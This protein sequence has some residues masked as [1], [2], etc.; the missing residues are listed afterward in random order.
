[1][2]NTSRRL[3]R[4]SIFVLL[5]IVCGYFFSHSSF[6]QVDTIVVTGNS[7]ISQHEIIDMARI[8][9]E[10]K[11]F[12]ANEK[13]I[14]QA[15]ELHP[16]IKEAQ[17]VRHLPRTLE[18]K[19]TERVMWAVVPLTD[20]FLIID[21]EGVCI[22][23]SLQFPSTEVPLITIEPVP[24][25][26]ILGQAVEPGGMD[27]IRKVWEGLSDGERQQVSDFHFAVASQQLTI[28]TLQG[29]EI[30]FGIDERLEEKL[31]TLSQ[32]FQLERDFI[33]TGQDDLIYVD[34]RYKG[35]PVVK[36]TI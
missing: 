25:Q 17:L 23:K 19:V 6:F 5:I 20:E 14:S 7:T 22:N 2:N 32:V 28:Y 3:F 24:Q 35:Q 36:T 27:L 21:T 30:K 9:D 26:I 16:M 29:T 18:I 12:E 11:L 34:M 4:A 13:L 15:V 8:E 1:M 33:D 31:S 10:I